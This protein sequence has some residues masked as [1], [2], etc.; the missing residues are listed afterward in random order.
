MPTITPEHIKNLTETIDLILKGC[1]S[2]SL[3]LYSYEA[4]N[5]LKTVYE[6][7]RFINEKIFSL[8]KE[9]ERQKHEVELKN[10]HITDGLNYAKRIQSAL[11]PRLTDLYVFFKDY[12]VFFKP[13]EIVSGDFYFFR[14][15]ENYFIFAA[16]DCTG[17]GVS[18]GFMSV[19]GLTS[20][21]EIVTKYT[22]KKK[23]DNN[24]PSNILNDLRLHIK[25][26]LSASDS[27]PLNDGMDIALCILDINSLKL[28]FA[29]ANNPIYVTRSNGLE[30]MDA[31]VTITSE[32][33]SLCEL[34]PDPQPIGTYII[35]TMF[36]NKTIQLYKNDCIY[37]FSDGFCD[38]IGGETKTR[39]KSLKFK[40]FLLSIQDLSMDDQKI[41]L[42]AE[43]KEWMENY[44]T[45]IDDMMV[46]GLKI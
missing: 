10:T 26:S 28:Y 40:H 44:H 6:S 14:H 30:F 11:L 43:N 16:A 4:D 29:G 35:E 3:N 15:V 34:K 41:A 1:V 21:N 12:F 24:T 2:P 33:H 45:Q 20:L 18:G 8:N 31:Q 37:L 46:I 17:H 32:T 25:T 5:E 7:L 36:T 19:L 27:T 42:N 39:Y 13:K 9:L 22:K 23:F 38:Q